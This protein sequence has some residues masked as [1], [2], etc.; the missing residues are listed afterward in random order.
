M[1]CVCDFFSPSFPLLILIKCILLFH[2]RIFVLSMRRT[3]FWV[4]LFFY[5][6]VCFVAIVWY[7]CATMI[8]TQW[9]TEIGFIFADP[10]NASNRKNEIDFIWLDLFYTYFFFCDDDSFDIYKIF[11]KGYMYLLPQKKNETFLFWFYFYINSFNEQRNELDV[12]WILCL[13]TFGNI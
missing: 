7:I 5:F 3:F 10:I 13:K 9:K 12:K 1:I 2:N 4:I 6:T 11:K 8:F